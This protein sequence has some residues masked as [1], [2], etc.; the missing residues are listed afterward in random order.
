[1]A[2][3]CLNYKP[4][5][6]LRRGQGIE[7]YTYIILD[8]VD[9]TNN[10]IWQC[11]IN[12]I[13]IA[14]EQTAGRGTKNKSWVSPKGNLYFSYLLATDNLL[15]TAVLSLLTGIACHTIMHTYTHDKLKIK[16]PNDL[17][18]DHNDKY[19]KVGGILIE[20]KY[21]NNQYLYA[22]GIGLN[23]QEI[24]SIHYQYIALQD[25][26]KNIPVKKYLTAE[27]ITKLNY[28]IKENTEKLNLSA[29]TYLM[30]NFYIQ[31]GDEFYQ[32]NKQ[33]I[34]QDIN[35]QTGQLILK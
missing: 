6:H 19:Y 21:L 22:I 1:M 17:L 5:I 14:D 2:T 8:T 29:Y 25:L 34:F 30:D 24:S 4:D 27:I 10:Y 28:L 7:V 18:K 32:D 23:I 15:N 31:S 26:P 33:Y 3:K 35:K 11:P 12:S 9:S 16:W 20:Q 13:V